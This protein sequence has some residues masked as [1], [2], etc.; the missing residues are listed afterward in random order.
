MYKENTDINNF[1]EEPQISLDFEAKRDVQPI[2]ET[3]KVVSLFSGCGG[4]DLGF[5][6]N[7][8]FKER[9]YNKN[10][11]E[12]V[13]SN[14]I[15]PAAEYVY[16]S[17]YEF[18]NHKLSC[19]DIKNI[20]V[21]LIP[22]FD[23]LLA[24]FPCQPFSN[25]GLRKG[26][27]DERGSL[28]EEC[29]KIL[30]HAVQSDHKPKAFIFENVKGIMSSKMADGT[31]IPDEIVKRTEKLGFKTSYKL[32]KTSNYGVPSNRHRLIIVGIREDFGYFD[33]NLLDNIVANYNLPNETSNP[34]ELYLGSAI[35]DI[36]INAPQSNDYW[37]YSPG[38]QYMVDK[39]GPCID[40]KDALEKFKA[41][42]PLSKISPT[43]SKGKSWKSMNP[44][45]MSERFRKI[46]DNPKKY[47]APNFYRRFALGEI[48]GTITASAQPENCGI[49]H[50]F[51]NRRFTIREI[52]RIQSFPDDFQFPYK[53]IAHAYKV[54][55]NAVPPVFA[56]VIAQALT[57]HLENE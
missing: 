52:A 45:D 51:E 22:Q 20:D 32:L 26:I 21:N 33:Y 13:F 15:D 23:V 24:G 47:H 39:I 50:P 19:N 2:Q 3:Y 27:N 37:K 53:S 1:I 29:E 38:G 34:Y 9:Y 44:D 25:A 28:F 40:G 46:W 4:L 11:F 42:T 43:I 18:F 16:N 49:T 12:I 7:F 10:K 36:P 30:L 41:K 57:K 14:D 54:I 55:G 5:C 8:V 31:S 17:N 48:N 6:G 35:C 56:W